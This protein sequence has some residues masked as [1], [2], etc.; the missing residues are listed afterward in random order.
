MYAPKHPMVVGM[1]TRRPTNV[2]RHDV[3]VLRNITILE[4]GTAKIAN[5]EVPRS[6]E[7]ERVKVDMPK[8]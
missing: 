4:K 8:R 7:V 1:S 6:P 3:L 5:V 2:D